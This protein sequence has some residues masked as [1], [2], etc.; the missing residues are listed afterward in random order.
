MTEINLPAN[1]SSVKDSAGSGAQNKPAN[2]RNKLRFRLLLVLMLVVAVI[3]GPWYYLHQRAYESTDN[4]FIEGEIIQISPRIG[5][6]VLSVHVGDN[7]HVNRGDLL[8]EIDPRDF[9]ARL[10]EAQ[11]RLNDLSA[12]AASAKSNFDLTT[13]VTDAVLIQT[14]AAWAAAQEQVKVLTA[15]TAQD[16]ANVDAAA[17]YLQQ[18]ES[19]RD[20][21]EA[22]ANRAAAD[23][24]RYRILYQKDEISRQLLDRS[25]ADARASAANLDAARQAILAAKAQLAQARAM[26]AATL[27][28]M[29][30]AEMQARQ[31]EGRVQEAQSAPQQRRARQSDLQAALSQ[32]EQQ[33]AVVRQAELNLSYTKIFSPE[34]GYVTRKSVE[35]GNIVQTGQALMALVSDQLWVVANFKETQLTHMRPGQPAAIRVDAYPRREFRAHVDSM[36]SG[37]GARF[38]LLPAE[39]ATGNYVKVVQR[40]PVKI[41][42]DEA[43]PPEYKLGPGMSVVPEVRVR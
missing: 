14:N 8:V 38:S 22:E 16:I 19:R 31:A 41:L 25:A 34:A 15:R 5:G 39:N 36:Q 20:A 35:P 37:T 7:Q 40:V 27:A 3:L 30:Q 4:A 18:S 26:Q 17:A 13:V 1:A 28:T 33:R 21:V 2:N 42:F 9:E 10:A 43:L 23:A 24:E 11:A 32:V 29:K 12:K 6:Q